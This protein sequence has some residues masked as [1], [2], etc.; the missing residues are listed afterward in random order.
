MIDDFAGFDFGEALGAKEIC[1]SA[2]TGGLHLE[3]GE[4]LGI[5]QADHSMIEYGLEGKTG[6]ILVHRHRRIGLGA[7]EHREILQGDFGAAGGL[8][9]DPH[10]SP[11]GDNRLHRQAERL[12][13]HQLDN[14]R[15]VAKY[16]EAQ[17]AEIANSMHPAG[18]GG[19]LSRPGEGIP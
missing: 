9:I 16:D 8:G 6:G 18:D 11:G 3:Y 4:Q 2:N 17:S 14:P 13:T 1:E 12:V 5:A 19:P 7:G 15:A 10:G